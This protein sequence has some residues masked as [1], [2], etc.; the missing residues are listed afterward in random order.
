MNERRFGGQIERLRFP[1]RIARLEVDRVV[2][3]SLAGLTA[4]S[5]LDI[6][7]G[8]GVFAEAFAARG[9]Q[10]AGIDLREDMLE[11]ARQY[12]PDGDFRQAPM[13]ALPFEDER[14]DVV[15]MG[16]VLHE[17][18]DLAEAFR[19]AYRVA[20]QR[21]MILEWN[22]E[23]GEFGPPIEHRLRPQQVFDGARGAGFQHAEQI[24]LAN[25]TLFRVDKPAP[26]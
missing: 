14:F 9:L 18:D 13:E 17:A 7:T 26:G 1:D 23:A 11:A 6:G 25:L 10:V 20:R 22:Y 24:T 2:D 15:F 12:I 19:Q 16:L 21:L 5:M 4:H 8:S 3:L